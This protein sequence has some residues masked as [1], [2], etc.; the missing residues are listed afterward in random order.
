VTATLPAALL[1]VI[2]WRTGHLS[3]R[4]NVVPLLPW[5]AIAVAAGSLTAWVESKYIGAQGAAFGL[6][7]LE[8]CLLAGRVIWFYLGKLFWPASLSFIYPHWQVRAA[9]WWQH[10]FPVAVVALVVT[11]WIIRPRRRGPLAALLFFV[12]TLF[13]A[14]GFFNVYPFVFSYVADHFQYL[15]SLGVIAAAAATLPAAVAHVG[16]GICRRGRLASAVWC[17]APLFGLGALGVLTYRQCQMYRDARTLYLAI[18]ENNPDCWLAHNNLGVALYAVRQGPAAIIQYNEAVRLKPDYADAYLNLGVALAAEGKAGD[19]IT[20][21]E[22][23]IKLRPEFAKAHNA[24]G[25]VLAQTGRLEEAIAHYEEARRIRSDIPETYNNLGIAAANEGK[26]GAAIAYGEQALRLDPGYAEAHYNL[27][28]VLARNGQ[29]DEAI[30][31][32]EAALRLKP[33][34]VEVH[35]SLG[36]ALGSAGQLNKAIRQ[37]ERALQLK[38]GDAET[39]FNFGLTLRAAGRLAEGQRELDEAARLGVGH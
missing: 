16:P 19:A 9:V 1:V 35:G 20:S 22:K 14:L 23:A 26:L 17:L 15:A 31:H 3:W 24:L 36:V 18:L 11:L 33:D 7:V 37:F 13:P 39:H 6:S 29:L 25:V 21:Y 8:R 12:G 2:W 4:R 10:L 34:F 27:G 28:L 38:P 30:S 5:F 32:Y